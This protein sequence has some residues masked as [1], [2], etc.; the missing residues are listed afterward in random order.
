MEDRFSDLSE[1]EYSEY[2][3]IGRLADV[4][5]RRMEEV[6]T[7]K[8]VTVNVN[9]MAAEVIKVVENRRIDDLVV[10]DDEGKVVGFIDIQDLPG[11]KIM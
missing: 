3:E 8:P 2:E 7:V 9:D 4:L 6:M 10:T 11:L 1:I 5:K